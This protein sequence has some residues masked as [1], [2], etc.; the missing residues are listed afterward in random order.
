MHKGK[1]KNKNNN[2][3]APVLF[4]RFLTSKSLSS[5]FCKFI[6]FF[7]FLAHRLIVL[8]PSPLSLPREAENSFRLKQLLWIVFSLLLRAKYWTINT[9]FSYVKF[10]F[11][12]SC[13]HFPQSA[14]LLSSYLFIVVVVVFNIFG[15]LSALLILLFLFYDYF[16]ATIY[17][18]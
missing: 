4:T 7:H 9:Y 12:P 14:A 6:R 8:C 11:L 2:K 5:F 16:F 1:A 18:G 3:S 13:L 15:C 10:F 17:H